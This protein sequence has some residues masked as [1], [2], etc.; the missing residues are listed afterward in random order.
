MMSDVII[1]AIFALATAGVIVPVASIAIL[2][3][4]R[5]GKE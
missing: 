5:N 2:K 1:F 3:A 4:L